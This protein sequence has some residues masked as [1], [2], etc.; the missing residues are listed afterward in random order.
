MPI[1]EERIISVHLFNIK[2]LFFVQLRCLQH[3]FCLMHFTSNKYNYFQAT[4]RITRLLA[5][6]RMIKMPDCDVYCARTRHAL[7]AHC[8]VLAA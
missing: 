3:D 6:I 4:S 7:A 1:D 2:F 5:R 8:L